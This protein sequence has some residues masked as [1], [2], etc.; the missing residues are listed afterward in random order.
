MKILQALFDRVILKALIPRNSSAVKT[1]IEENIGEVVS[2]GPEVNP[3]IKIGHSVVFL[4]S[5]SFLFEG[6]RYFIC[7][8]KDIIP[9]IK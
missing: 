6:V 7:D 5:N 8:Q 9:I 3:A 2:A 4:S 1:T